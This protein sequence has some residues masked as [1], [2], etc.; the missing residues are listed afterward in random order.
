VASALPPLR[1]DEVA[2]SSFNDEEVSKGVTRISTTYLAKENA[3]GPS[4]PPPRG[5]GPRTRSTWLVPSGI[6]LA[7]ALVVRLPI[8]G[9]AREETMSADAAHFLDVARCVARGQGYSNPAAWPAWLDPARLPM[10]ETFKDPG[11]PYAIAAVAPLAGGLFHGGILIALLAGLALPLVTYALG[12]R[13]TGDHT[14]ALVAGLLVAASPLLAVYSL[15]VMSES[16]FVLTLTL[17]F[18]LATPEAAVAGRVATGGTAR[19]PP[20]ATVPTT[21]AKVPSTAVFAS[22]TTVS[23]TA[24]FL[25]GAVLGLAFLVRMQALIAIPAIAWLLLSRS[26]LRAGL[27]RLALA[28]AGLLPVVSPL[29]IRNLRLFGTPL[30][31]DATTFVLWPYLDPITFSHGLDRPPP[32]LPFLAAHAGAVARHVAANLVHLLRGAIARELIGHVLWLPPLLIGGAITLTRPRTWG[33]AWIYMVPAALAMAAMSWNTR[34]FASL[35]PGLALMAAVGAAWL[36]ERVALERRSPAARTLAIAA[37]VVLLA[38]QA[39]R[40]WRGAEEP[41]PPELGAALAARHDPRLTLAPDEAI[42]AITT[43]YWSWCLDRPSVHLPIGDPARVAAIARRLHVR[44]A[45]LPTSRLAE[46]EARYP[47]GRLPAMFVPAWS[48]A[49]HDLTVF[50]VRDSAPPR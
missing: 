42:I 39:S 17:A 13:L 49:A 34:Y 45:A 23:P 11:F 1:L 12:L 40:A 43:S 25:A 20:V 33:F 6:L 50:A 26:S 27:G 8:L 3:V 9:S 10:P 41:A 14:T 48:D 15:R 22:A 7:A 38:F 2:R 32:A 36:A 28:A 37:L 35:V 31:S 5:R 46:L 19:T 44:W 29:L 18:L 24:A 30:H 16:L 47:G 4:G 21:A